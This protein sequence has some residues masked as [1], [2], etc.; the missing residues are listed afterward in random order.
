MHE[1]GHGLGFQNFENEASGT[2]LAGRQDIYSVFTFD[3]TAGKYWTQMTVPERR[4][5]ALNYGQ[6]VFDG[7]RPPLG[8]GLPLDPRTAFT[9][10]APPPPAAV[11]GS[12]PPALGPASPPP[13]IDPPAYQGTP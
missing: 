5:S 6:V 2:F 3:N 9:C 7:A 11:S 1:F 13:S 8:P 12:R 4:A 10:P